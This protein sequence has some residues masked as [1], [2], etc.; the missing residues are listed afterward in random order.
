MMWII[1]DKAQ[2]ATQII[3][4]TAQAATQAMTNETYNTVVMFVIVATALIFVV[5]ALAFAWVA[6]AAFNSQ[7]PGAPKSLGLL[8]QRSDSLRLGTVM[9]VVLAVV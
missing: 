4:D 6:R 2:A 7:R 1:Q 5:A 3:Q 9:V 8:F